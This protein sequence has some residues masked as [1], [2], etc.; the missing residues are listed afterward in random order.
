V[1]V[2]LLQRWYAYYICYHQQGNRVIQVT[3]RALNELDNP[4]ILARRWVEETGHKYTISLVKK[5]LEIFP[6]RIVELLVFLTSAV[7]AIP[8]TAV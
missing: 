5:V 4:N 3:V 1:A 2:R 7:M 8:I 6:Q